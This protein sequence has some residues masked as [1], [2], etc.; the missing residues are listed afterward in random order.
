VVR[1]ESAKRMRAA[2][3][4]HLEIPFHLILRVCCLISSPSARGL[5]QLAV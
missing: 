1:M 2:M 4:P 3:V 5:M